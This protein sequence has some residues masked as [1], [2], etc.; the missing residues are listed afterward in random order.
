MKRRVLSLTL[1]L[2]LVISLLPIDAFADLQSGGGA[3]APQR[4]AFSDVA[5]SDWYYGAVGYAVENGLFNG[6]GAGLFDPGG[7]MTRGMFVTVLGRIAGIEPA[8]YPH[9]GGFADVGEG[10]YYAPYIAW[11]VENGITQGT[12]EGRF[13]PDGLVTR[14]QMAV[15]TAR[16][17]EALGIDMDDEIEAAGPGDLSAVSLWAKDAVLRLWRAGLLGGDE[18]GNFNPRAALSRAE[19]ATVGMRVH[20]TAEAQSETV[21]VLAPE[22]SGGSGGSHSDDDGGTPS[23][24]TV[25]FD[26]DGGSE[27]AAVTVPRGGTVPNL[28]TPQKMGF[29]FLGWYREPSFASQFTAD[30]AVTSSLTLYAKYAEL[31][32]VTSMQDERFALINQETSLSFT[33]MSDDSMNEAEVQGAL[34]L[35]R[36][37]G[38][39][40]ETLEVEEGPQ[41]SYIVQAGGGFTPGAAYTLTLDE[42]ALTFSGREGSVRTCSFTIEQE[43]ADDLPLSGGIRYIPAGE[44]SDIIKN[45]E[46]V[47]SLSVPLVSDEEIT[48]IAGTFTYGG[49]EALSVGD[50][51]CVYSGDTP[52]DAD[53]DNEDIL[54]QDIAYVEVTGV[55]GTEISYMQAA[56]E[57]VLALPDMLPIYVG[58]GSTYGGYSQEGDSVT[59]DL[60]DLDFSQ[61]SDIGL[62]G[63]TVIDV[64]DY[65]CFYT[66]PV[67][68][69]TTEDEFLGYAVV[70]DVT[71]EGA[72]AIAVAYEPVTL[73]EMQA[74]LGYYSETPVS[75]ETLL[76]G[77]DVEALEAGLERQA[78]ESGFARQ[79]ALYLSAVTMATDGFEE[80]TGERID[81]TLTPEALGAGAVTPLSLAGD[82]EVSVEAHIGTDTQKLGRSGVRAAVTVHFSAPVSVG[83]G[84]VV[85]SGSA[86]FVEELSVSFDVSGN[87]VWDGWFIF[88]WIKDYNI[89]SY[90]NVYNYTAMSIDV[91]LRSQGGDM[92]FDVSDEIQELLTSTDSAEIVSG[93]GEL[94]DTYCELLGGGADWIDLFTQNIFDHRM[95]ILFGIIQIKL[96]ADFV[97]SAYVNVALGTGF[98]YSSGT[99]YAFYGGIFARNFRSYTQELADEVFNFHFY[100]LGELGIRAGIRLELAVGLFNCD[101]DSVGFTAECGVYAKLYGYF[102]YEYRR[103]NDVSSTLSTGA[104]YFELGIYLEI[105]FVA[106]VGNGAVSSSWTLYENEWPLLTAGTRC[107]VVNFISPDTPEIRLK[108]DN[109]T[110]KLPK[111]FLTMKSL[112]LREGSWFEQIYPPSNFTVTFTDDAFSLSGDTVTVAPGA[113]DRRLTCDM[114][115]TW[116]HGAMAFS[117]LPISRTYRMQWDDI[118]DGGYRIS[119]EPNGG[120]Y[121]ST[122]SA[123]YEEPVSALAAPSKTGYTFDGWYSDPELTSPYAFTVMPGA[124]FTLY[125]KW[126]PRTDTAY[127]VRHYEQGL[128]N[129]GS[130]TLVHTERLAGT[131]DASVTPGTDTYTGF[132]S[133]AAQTVTIAPDGSTAVSYYYIRTTYNVRFVAAGDE[134]GNADVTFQVKYGGRIPAP[135]I[136]KPGYRLYYWELGVPDSTPDEIM[137][138]MPASDLTYTARWRAETY[139]VTF[140]S[141]GGL[142]C[143]PVTVQYDFVYG[144]LPG[145]IPAPGSGL[146]FTGWYLS[147]TT[148]P[149]TGAETGSGTRVEPG[150][151][152]TIP[153]GHILYAGWR[154]SDLVPYTVRHYVADGASESG[155]TLMAAY[156]YYA[157]GNTMATAP[158]KTFAGYVTPVS[159]QVLV[160]NDGETVFRYDYPRAS[161]SLTLFYAADSTDYTQSFH[162]AGSNI[163]APEEPT[164]TGYTFTGWEPAIPAKMPAWDIA[165][166]AQWQKKTYTILLSPNGATTAGTGFATVE[167]EG[168]R[169]SAITNPKKTG[170]RFTGWYT[171]GGVLLID[172]YGSFVYSPDALTY[173][174]AEGGAAK[175]IYDGTV[176]LTAHWEEASGVTTYGEL[177][178]ALADSSEEPIVIAQTIAIPDGA[179]I[180]GGGHTIHNEAYADAD[181]LDPVFTFEG[182]ATI[183]D[184]TIVGG[185]DGGA[186]MPEQPVTLENVTLE[187]ATLMLMGGGTLTDCIFTGSKMAVWLGGDTLMQNCTVDRDHED[188]TSAIQ[189]SGA[190]LVMENCSVTNNSGHGI[191]TYEATLLMNNC[192]VANNGNCG[193]YDWG[194]STI[195]ALNSTFAGNAVS[196]CRLGAGTAAV[197]V[198]TV[199]AENL[200]DFDL[201]LE[202]GDEDVTLIHCVY[203]VCEEEQLTILN[204]LALDVPGLFAGYEGGKPAL[205]QLSDGTWAAPLAAES[206]A[207]TGGCDT[208]FS[209][210]D[211]CAAYGDTPVYVA[212]E[213]GA[214]EVTVCQ[215]GAARASG[216]IGAYG[217]AE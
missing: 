13:E 60:E 169:T 163:P 214:N 194:P 52:P 126:A 123:L 115:V 189:V 101:W 40:P 217:T 133:P 210:E 34:T 124:N 143:A 47:A 179:V 170:S 93:V 49:G 38:S 121:V 200:A 184:L 182:G 135:N 191:Y 173:L 74:G 144:T 141:L 202:T 22:N 193:L 109:K 127:T 12:G 36:A 111:T 168:T 20:E 72:A 30:I 31:E 48:E 119:F 54:T 84:E 150:T 146:T 110:F 162:A 43:E 176:T 29:V 129:E 104:L 99:C 59:A 63:R 27:I 80:T 212:G 120:S 117:S 130:Y 33:L 148:D 39:E 21:P 88:W 100:V 211:G 82:I 199:L 97:V 156:T 81:Y 9:T 137:T 112:D 92:S 16:F 206:P 201:E 139:A 69:E 157:Q 203:G 197:F 94:L 75:G 24:C 195:T 205:T 44:L 161:R 14:E 3:P 136:W 7:A 1:V 91:V 122:L 96:S 66:N 167:Y 107:S 95:S 142:P 68:S 42:E 178:T 8:D 192:T 61:F 41:D 207:L 125:A 116:N 98:E 76:E 6:T 151:Q 174:S 181:L 45:G 177:L 90:T 188:S 108:Y 102:Y 187:G 147:K 25:R 208:Y 89:Y 62:D 32:S 165:A 86:T 118:D 175:W 67:F 145:S 152:V 71:P 149:A 159:Q 23:R 113:G 78:I 57:N 180:D 183:Q 160:R 215:G 51:L 134:T 106:Q 17:F 198:N 64:G 28:P 37:D 35:A 4:E 172:P 55:D 5:Q 11:A 73:E 2:C 77:T 213:T 204:S 87:A 65:L 19:C 186:L 140:D 103:V 164:R 46:S 196:G 216:T 10:A 209:A 70:T 171:S 83:D 154:Q 153:G 185:E 58:D 53:A 15:F 190:S 138:V 18:N 50:T 105:N 158:T 56:T 79:A 128:A 114:T 85:I 26:T 132:T 155:Y 166:T 131:T